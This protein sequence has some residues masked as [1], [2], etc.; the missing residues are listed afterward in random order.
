MV[1]VANLVLSSKYGF[2]ERRKCAIEDVGRF[3]SPNDGVSG[4]AFSDL[5]VARSQSAAQHRN[6]HYQL[7][8]YTQRACSSGASCELLHEMYQ[9]HTLTVKDP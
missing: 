5:L 3:A 2:D 9:S 6:I 7:D 4:G 8:E 1:D